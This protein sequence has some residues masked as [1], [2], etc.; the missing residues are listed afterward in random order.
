MLVP[1]IT[2]NR[3]SRTSSPVDQKNSPLAPRIALTPLILRDSYV[4][5]GR[6]L[7]MSRLGHSQSQHLAPSRR[8]TSL[9]VERLLA[10]IGPTPKYV[11]QK[12]EKDAGTTIL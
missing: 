7:G 10:R 5:A 11:R 3:C 2:W 6:K 9:R 12:S 8:V 1:Q 4:L